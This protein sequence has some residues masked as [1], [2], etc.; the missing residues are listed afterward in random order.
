MIVVVPVDLLVLAG[1]WPG[2]NEGYFRG[3][4]SGVGDRPV[5]I[6]LVA[7]LGYFLVGY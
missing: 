2:R 6:G 1:W 7:L 4:A 3:V 5:I